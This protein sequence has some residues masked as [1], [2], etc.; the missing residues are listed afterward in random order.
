MSSIYSS[1]NRKKRRARKVIGGASV[2]I[3]VGAVFGYPFGYFLVPLMQFQAEALR[4]AYASGPTFA[5]LF[6]VLGLVV[7]GR[8]GDFK[9]R[10]M[11]RVEFQNARARRFG[12]DI[13]A[14][15]DYVGEG[16]DPADTDGYNKSDPE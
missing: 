5:W 4:D 3:L 13:T 2:G 14:F 12:G 16:H 11:R 15:R 1:W 9:Y 6:A 8:I 7:G 10:K